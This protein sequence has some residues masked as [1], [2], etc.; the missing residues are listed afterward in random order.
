METTMMEKL[1]AALDTNDPDRAVDAFIEIM[2]LIGVIEK[3][4]HDK[5]CAYRTK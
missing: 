5:G 1:Q 2:K 4:Y 3:D